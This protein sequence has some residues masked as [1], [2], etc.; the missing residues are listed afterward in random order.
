[1]RD[2]ET[3]NIHLHAHLNKCQSYPVQLR[4]HRAL[5]PIEVNSYP[6][7]L[8]WVAAIRDTATAA[9]VAIK[10]N[11]IQE[12]SEGCGEGKVENGDVTKNCVR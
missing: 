12:T 8:R 9:D 3:N 7:A 1:M 10:L 11:L 6:I 4:T 2:D 5:V